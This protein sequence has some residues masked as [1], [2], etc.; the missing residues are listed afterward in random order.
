[1]MS[2]KFALGGDEAVYEMSRN[3][4]TRGI[5]IFLT[6]RDATHDEEVEQFQK[7]ME[8][9]NKLPEAQSANAIPLIIESAPFS[10]KNKE[11]IAQS[12]TPQEP[13]PEAQQLTARQ[14]EANVRLVEAQ[15]SQLE[16]QAKM[17][18]AQGAVAERESVLKLEEMMAKIERLV[19]QAMKDR[20]DAAL[21]M[22][23]TEKTV[24]E[25]D[26]TGVETVMTM[27]EPLRQSVIQQ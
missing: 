12:L 26:K 14:T 11:K 4:I 15:A 17:E 16:G 5:S 9:I 10:L 27:T 6:E 13:S 1:M 20:A 8:V 22:A 25:T 19:T 3:D 2:L 18:G 24:A 7:I 21:T 23:E